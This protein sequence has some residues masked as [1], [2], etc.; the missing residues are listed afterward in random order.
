MIKTF[1]LYLGYALATMT[2][3]SVSY[4]NLAPQFGSNPLKKEKIEYEKLTNFEDGIFINSES[5]P[6]MTGEVSTWDFFKSDSLRKPKI[7]KL[8]KLVILF[9]I[10]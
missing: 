1:F 9:L 8:K 3:T 4:L 5:T 7:L 10:N 6:L 2:V